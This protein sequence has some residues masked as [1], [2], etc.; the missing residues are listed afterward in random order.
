VTWGDEGTEMAFK[1]LLALHFK[2]N[3][4]QKVFLFKLNASM[5]V[6]LSHVCFWL[7]ITADLDMSKVPGA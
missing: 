6:K 4:K 1:S 5:F 7:P 2:K 3:Q